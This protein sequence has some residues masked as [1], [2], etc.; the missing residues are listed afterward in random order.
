MICFY[1]SLSF[2]ATLIY[3][4]VWQRALFAIYGVN[5]QSVAVVVSAF[6]LGLGIGSLLGGRLSEAFPERGI[7]IF[8]ICELGVAGFGLISLRLFHWASAYTA[9]TGL[10][11]TILFS[12]LLLSELERA[13]LRRIIYGKLYGV[14]NDEISRALVVPRL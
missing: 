2:S 5:V 8:G 11:Y 7:L 3:Q 9:G 6:L 13:D 4:I 1:W 14:P 12:F 10:G